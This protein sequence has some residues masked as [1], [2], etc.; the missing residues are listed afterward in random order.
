MTT[1]AS[2]ALSQRLRTIPLSAERGSIFD[3]NGR[4]LAIS[5]ERSSV[6]AD[7]TLVTDPALYASKLSPVVGVDSRTHCTNG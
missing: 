1:T 4:D 5:I 6:Y 3:R 2:I 7:P